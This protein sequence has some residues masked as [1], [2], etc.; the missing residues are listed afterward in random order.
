VSKDGVDHKNDASHTNLTGSSERL[1]KMLEAQ[2]V[3]E[4]KADLSHLLETLSKQ[5]RKKPTLF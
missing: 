2:D 1:L 5:H 3:S 4:D